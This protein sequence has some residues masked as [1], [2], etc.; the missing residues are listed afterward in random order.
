MKL[1]GKKIRKTFICIAMAFVV[2][3]ASVM[4]YQI[5][6]HAETVKTGMITGD[7]VNFRKGPGTS[8]AS[9]GKYN[10]GKTGTYLGEG[11][12]SNGKLWYNLKIDGV[13]GWVHSDYVKIITAESSD[14]AF[15]AYLTSQGFP[16]D[17]KQSLRVL[18]EQYPNWIF[19][20]QHTN[21][22]WNTVIAEESKLGRNLVH[23]SAETSWKSTADGAYNWETGEWKVNV[24]IGETPSPGALFRASGGALW[25][26]NHDTCL[27]HSLQKPFPSTAVAGAPQAQ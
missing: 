27:S 19:E 5:P 24:G 23:S 12:A 14:A 7:G 6:V 26:D 11:T 16:E 9:L 13:S 3:T 8:Y 15:E 22:D 4:T 10:Y 18:H 1:F 20:A 17:Y 21:L 2:V 25:T